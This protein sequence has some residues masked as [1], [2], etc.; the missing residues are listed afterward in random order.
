MSIDRVDYIAKILAARKAVDE[1]NLLAKGG[2]IDPEWKNAVPLKGKV[3][4]GS[5]HYD[6]NLV[7]SF[8]DG[9][10]IAFCVVGSCSNCDAESEVEIERDT[11]ADYDALLRAEA[12]SQEEHARI[13]AVHDEQRVASYAAARE[14]DRR[15]YERLKREFEGAETAK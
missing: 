9:T 5:A 11:H 12:I 4:R 3:V 6:D 10:H 13:K 14:A 1:R 7:I 15:T 8:E 2:T